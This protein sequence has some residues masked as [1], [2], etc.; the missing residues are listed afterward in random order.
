MSL[1]LLLSNPSLDGRLDLERIATDSLIEYLK[2]LAF[3]KVDGGSFVVNTFFR[4]FPTH[5]EEVNT[6]AISVTAGTTVFDGDLFPRVIQETY[7]PMKKT[8]LVKCGDATIPLQIDCLAS[9]P[10]QRSEMMR[11]LERALVCVGFDERALV[12][13]AK[14]YHDRKIVYTFDSAISSF[15]TAQG[16]EAGE[17][18]AVLIGEAFLEH[19]EERSLAPAKII[20]HLEIVREFA[21]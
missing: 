21:A 11:T 5:E 7:D 19:V 16:A 20:H 14:N 12:L 3:S 2:G 9:L 4:E 1:V 18:R 8:A 17:R 6:P 10:I 15:E 13:T